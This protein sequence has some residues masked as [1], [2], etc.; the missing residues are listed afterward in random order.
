MIIGSTVTDDI[1]E[2]VRRNKVVQKILTQND[3]LFLDAKMRFASRQ[4]IYLGRDEVLYKVFF[5]VRKPVK[6]IMDKITNFFA[7]KKYLSTS[8]HSAQTN[9]ALLKNEKR[10][11]NLLLDL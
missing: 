2:A 1:V 6:N 10:I 3:D 5:S 11:S 4:E 8:Y 7:A 9:S